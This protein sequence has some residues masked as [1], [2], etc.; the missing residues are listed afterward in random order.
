MTP[1]YSIYCPSHMN[2]LLK[3]TVQV[4]SC[5]V[6]DIFSVA[7]SAFITVVYPLLRVMTSNSAVW[8][9]LLMRF[10][11]LSEFY[12]LPSALGRFHSRCWFSV[13]HSG[14][15]DDEGRFPEKFNYR[16][17]SKPERL[18][19]IIPIQSPPV[20]C[21]PLSSYFPRPIFVGLVAKL[22]TL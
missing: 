21:F 20:C 22:I 12:R 1:T 3:Y 18:G 6:S 9:F 17:V 5:K 2:L 19:N 15:E 11:I 4:Q 16:Q 8:F 14:A 7:S 10:I 13:S